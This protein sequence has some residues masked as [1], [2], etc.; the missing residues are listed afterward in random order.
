[1]RVELTGC[2][3][4]RFLEPDPLLLVNE[5]GREGNVTNPKFHS[6]N[7][8]IVQLVSSRPNTEVDSPHSDE[9]I[10][11]HPLVSFLPLD[12][13]SPDSLE[14]VI[15]HIDH[16]MQYGEDEEPKEVSSEWRLDFP[17]SC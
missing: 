6:L 17:E 11:Y 9:Q 7:K 3:L 1:M 10:E 15:S 8:A 2:P 16:V 13:T 14:Y 4:S 5:P 12:L